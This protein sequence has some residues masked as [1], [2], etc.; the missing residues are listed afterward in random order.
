[1]KISVI[2]VGDSIVFICQNVAATAKV[3][4]VPSERSQYFKVTLTSE[5]DRFQSGDN[6]YVDSEEIVFVSRK[7]LQT[8]Q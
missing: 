6:L 3:V 4:A 2:K 1:M 8:K 5:W 7:P